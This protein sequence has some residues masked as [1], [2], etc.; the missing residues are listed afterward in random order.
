MKSRN[1]FAASLFALLLALLAGQTLAET[2]PAELSVLTAIEKDGR[3][4]FGGY[5]SRGYF[6][7]PVLGVVK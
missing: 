7:Q 5:L 4:F 2:Q 1:A 3:I 6:R